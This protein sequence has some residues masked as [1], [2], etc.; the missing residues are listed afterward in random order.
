MKKSSWFKMAATGADSAELSIYGEVGM[1]PD[2]ASTFRRALKGLGDGIKKLA[3]RINSPGGSVIDGWAI[4]NMLR[5]H[6]AEKTAYID[7]WAASMAGII[8][9]AAEKVVQPRN[10]WLMIHNP[11]TVAVG[12]SGAMRKMADVMDAMKGH[13]IEAYQRHVKASKEVIA[14]WMDK[15]TW[16]TGDD[17]KATGWDHEITDPLAVSASVDIGRLAKVPEAAMEWIAKREDYIDGITTSTATPADAPTVVGETSADDAELAVLLEDADEAYEE[18][19]N[20][21][22]SDAKASAKDQ[23]FADTAMI[24][25]LHAKLA[26]TEVDRAAAETRATEIT[27]VAAV[28]LLTLKTAS[29][30][31]LA[32]QKEID[33]T[34][35]AEAMAFAENTL[36]EVKAEAAKVLDAEKAD[37]AATLLKLAKLTVGLGA[38]PLDGTPRDW[39]SVMAAARA[40]GLGYNAAH[41]ECSRLY[42]ELLREYLAEVNP[43]PKPKR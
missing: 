4:Y 16:L 42:P 36:V 35:L 8:A 5:D 6:P 3:I 26:A 29:E 24:A 32:D 28:D 15:E 30:K 38:P 27:K 12:D 9:M 34:A 2:D 13:A 18:G 22:F 33:S 23:H 20:A 1:W 43:H 17:A 14:E 11:W 19:F 7:G 37:H 39:K 10:T 41:D 21:G 25:D 31:A 40:R